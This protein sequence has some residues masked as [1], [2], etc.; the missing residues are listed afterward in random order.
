MFSCEFYKV[1]DSI[2]F[3]EHIRAVFLYLSGIFGKKAFWTFSVFQKL[4]CKLGL[5]IIWLLHN[6]YHCIVI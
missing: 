3:T 5:K 6:R 4:N 1:F 2:Y